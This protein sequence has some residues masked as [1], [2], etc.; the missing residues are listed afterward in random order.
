METH[1][2]WLE[3]VFDKLDVA[4]IS[5][6]HA[7]GRVLRANEAYARMFGFASVEDAVGHS[8][9]EHYADPKE[10]GEIEARLLA[11]ESFRE[12]GVARMELQRLRLDTREPIDVLVAVFATF[13][14]DGRVVRMEATLED[15][16][17]RKRAEKAFRA[18]EERFRTVFETSNVGMALTDLE[19]HIQRPNGALCQFLGR[20]E[21]ELLGVD[22][23]SLVHPDDRPERPPPG[24]QRVPGVSRR[25]LRF[26]RPSGEIAWGYVTFSWLSDGD[27]APHS[28]FAVVHDISERKRVEQDLL[29]LAKLESLGVL[30]GGIAHD[31]NNLLAVILGNVSFARQLPEGGPRTRELLRAAEVACLQAR[32]LAQKL[33]TFAKGGAPQKRRGSIAELLRETASFYA[34]DGMVALEL[35]EDL[36]LADFDTGHMGQVIHNLLVN[37]RQA[38]PDGGAIRVEG[39]N[40]DVDAS[41]GTPVPP[42]RYVRIRVIDEGCGIPPENLD[43]IFDPYFTTKETGSGLGLATSHSIVLRHGG[44]ISVTSTLGRGATFD[45]YLPASDG[46]REAQLVAATPSREAVR[47]RALVM[48]DEPLVRDLVAKLLR[49]QGLVVDAVAKGEEAIEAFE[50]ALRAGTRYDLVLLDLT[51]RGGLDGIATITRLRSIDESVKAI[52]MTGYSPDLAA[53]SAREMGFSAVVWKPFRATQLDAAV[54]EVLGY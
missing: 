25:E 12:T 1:E 2:G 29:R 47:A 37:A 34:R 5:I 45:V 40:V 21:A 46:G 43:R 26:V 13:G 39:A 48:D 41:H 54:R 44:H 22:A 49:E 35:P 50:T 17:E 16:G 4:V 18:S 6:E 28:V 36:W 42:G 52:V 32:D 8:V 15:I 51:I 23:L 53:A 9:V 3:H 27:G 11:S 31:F 38:M 10:R 24:E 14:P 33:V 19:G 30:A 20:S 7:T